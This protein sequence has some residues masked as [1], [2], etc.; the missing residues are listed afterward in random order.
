[1]LEP[2]HRDQAAR[3][4]GQHVL[5]PGQMSLQQQRHRCLPHAAALF[6]NHI[7]HAA[8]DLEEDRRVGIV[9]V[10]AQ[11]QLVAV[12]VAVDRAP[13]DLQIIRVQIETVDR[14]GVIGAAHPIL[15]HRQVTADKIAHALGGDL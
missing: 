12:L 11:P 8:L 10:I 2:L 9:A 5:P 15:V 14:I 4:L 3:V 1:M 7:L 13:I 6:E